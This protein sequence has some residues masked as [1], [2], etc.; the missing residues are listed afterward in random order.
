MT[1]TLEKIA[2]NKYFIGV[3]MIMMNIGARF[4]IEELTPK[5]K[6]WINTQTFRRFIVFCA[7]FAA[8]RDLLAAVT[9]TIIFILFVGEFSTDS[10]DVKN[11]KKKKIT[12][13][14]IQNEL[15][16]VINKVRMMAE[17]DKQPE[18]IAKKSS[19]PIIVKNIDQ[20]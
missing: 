19:T 3:V 14:D 6:E 9:L 20:F 11:Q 1:N 12:N 17:D 7:F 10:N 4:M 13:I 2:E 5:Q 15:N 18:V 8:T 16:S